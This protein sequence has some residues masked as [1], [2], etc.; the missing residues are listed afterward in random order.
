MSNAC[1]LVD[2]ETPLT[3]PMPNSPS[4]GRGIYLV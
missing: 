3:S 1:A 4:R 2:C